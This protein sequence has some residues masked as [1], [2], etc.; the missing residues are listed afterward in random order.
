MENEMKRNEI[1]RAWLELF[2]FMTSSARNCVG[3]PPM[4][5]PF[6]LIDSVEKIIT[7][8]EKQGLA[9]DFFKKKR[10]KI[11]ENKLVL[12]T[13]KEAFIELLDELVMDFTKELKA[14]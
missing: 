4:Y 13:D 11:E 3:E 2:C 1:K 9:D 8:L 6:R 14:Y 5:G 7:I 12:V 10:A